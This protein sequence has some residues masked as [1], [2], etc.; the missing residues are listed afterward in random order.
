MS[1]LKKQVGQAI[2]EVVAHALPKRL[3]LNDT[4]FQVWERRGWHVTPVGHYQPVPELSALPDS[5]WTRRSAMVGVEMRDAAQVAWLSENAA[6]FRTELDALPL[7]PTDKVGEFY[8]HN[9][10][11]GSVDAEVYW[12]MLRQLKPRRVMEIGSGNSTKLAARA[13]LQNQADGAQACEF[14]AIEPYPPA[15]LTAGI[16]G[17]TRL[18]PEKLEALPLTH[19]DAL[20]AGDVLFIDSSHMLRIGS[21]VQFEYL[22]ILPRLKPGVIVHIHDIFLPAEY[23]RNWVHDKHIFWNEQYLLQAFLAF[24]ASFE[25]LWGGSWM[26]LNHPAELESAFQ[27]YKRENQWPGSFWIR[28]VQ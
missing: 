25:V 11:F 19:F 26:H 13:L 17:L 23:P 3:M 6:R 8:V 18:L 9:G 16:P 21:D 10:S 4:F 15:Y 2:A 1:T 27:S 12:C 7:T 20:E 14:T 24:N 28:R 22:E 5:L